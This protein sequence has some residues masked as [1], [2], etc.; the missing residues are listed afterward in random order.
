MP[1][2][3]TVVCLDPQSVVGGLTDGRTDG[4]GLYGLTEVMDLMVL[5]E[6]MVLT[7]VIVPT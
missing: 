7:G 6:V 4:Q 3:L 5:T 1:V 2:M